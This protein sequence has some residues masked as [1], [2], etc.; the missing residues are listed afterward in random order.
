MSDI[1]TLRACT[2]AV[3]DFLFFNRA[4]SGHRLLLGDVTLVDDVIVFR[5]RRT[6]GTRG[7]V[8]RERVRSCP[9]LGY[10]RIPILFA[11]W[12]EAHHA[13]WSRHCPAATHFWA[14]PGES[15]PSARTISTWFSHLLGAHPDLLPAIPHRHHDLRAGARRP[16]SPS[17]FLSRTFERG[18][19]G[20]R[21]A[22]PS[23]ST[24]TWIGS[25]PRGTSASLAG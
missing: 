25:P 8:P 18:A 22:E 9:T 17:R 14:L 10:P 2:S 23:E 11:H 12:L 1:K 7:S 3:L 24:S 21:V 4:V 19:V 5:E 20:W 15:A 6:K 16:A 13:A